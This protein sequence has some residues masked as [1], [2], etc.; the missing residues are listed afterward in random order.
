MVLGEREEVVVFQTSCRCGDSRRG[1]GKA[2][3]L[4]LVWL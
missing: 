1:A 4:I 3:I 2:L